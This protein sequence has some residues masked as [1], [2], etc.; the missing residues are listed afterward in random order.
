MNNIIEQRNQR[1]ADLSR[2]N[3]AYRQENAAKD[4]IIAELQRRLGLND[5]NVN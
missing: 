2:E 3:V 1:I 4:R 5:T